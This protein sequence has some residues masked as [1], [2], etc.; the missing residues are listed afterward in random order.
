MF[1]KLYSQLKPGGALIIFDKTDNFNGYLN[2]VVHRMT[3]AG[4]VAT[5]T[6]SEDIVKKELS[7]A[8]AQRPIQTSIFNLNTFEI[9]RF[10]EFAGWVAVK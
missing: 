9:F 2:T 7:L 5:N 8:G 10:G 6:P 3:I 1:D 4:K